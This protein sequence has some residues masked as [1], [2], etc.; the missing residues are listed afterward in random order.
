MNTE[1]SA[2]CPA[3]RPRSFDCE[4][5]PEPPRG[6]AEQGFIPKSCFYRPRVLNLI[7]SVTFRPF[8]VL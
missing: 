1:N 7:A 6:L 5:T 8:T 2:A 3:F 4:R